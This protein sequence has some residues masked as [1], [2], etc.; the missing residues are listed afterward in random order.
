LK[1]SPCFECLVLP[2][3]KAKLSSDYLPQ[4]THLALSCYMLSR[5][6]GHPRNVPVNQICEYDNH[7]KNRQE[8]INK[9][10]VVF[11]LEPAG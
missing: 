11:K 5:Y 8:R 3:C 2:I 6:L 10:R 1:E 7:V 4:V 9:T